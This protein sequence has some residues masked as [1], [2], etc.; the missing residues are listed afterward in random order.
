[1][2]DKLPHGVFVVGTKLMGVCQ[3]CGKL[4][5]LDKPLFGSMHICLSDEEIASKN[6]YINKKDIM[7]GSPININ[8]IPQGKHG[9]E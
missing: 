8:L 9:D 3:V 2:S 6:N 7:L 5:R 1:M 4:V